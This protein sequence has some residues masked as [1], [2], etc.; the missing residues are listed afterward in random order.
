LPNH[1]IEPAITFRAPDRFVATGQ[2]RTQLPEN[3]R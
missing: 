2:V 1:K 3:R